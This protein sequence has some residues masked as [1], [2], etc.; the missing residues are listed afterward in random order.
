MSSDTPQRSKK[1]A[2]QA[3]PA[4]AT[5]AVKTARARPGAR[6]KTAPAPST[7]VKSKPA[8]KRLCGACQGA[9]SAAALYCR[10]CGKALSAEVP[11][12]PFLPPPPKP[13]RP[14]R[15]PKQRPAAA[16][17]SQPTPAQAP[18][19]DAGPGQSW[20]SAQ[21]EPEQAATM[22]TETVL[23]NPVSDP[24]PE[25]AAGQAP[26]P[27]VKKALPAPVQPPEP[28][29]WDPVPEVEQRMAQLQAIHDRLRPQLARA[30]LF[31]SRLR[32]P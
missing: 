27:P 15:I 18:G 17:H 19:A 2:R 22:P 29:T 6:K 12:N 7:S 31:K 23:V 16:P 10:H 8:S 13:W 5:A 21:H 25:V 30:D 14:S 26:V 24:G 4:K 9:V 1:S 32:H 3:T 20:R 11:A 28:R